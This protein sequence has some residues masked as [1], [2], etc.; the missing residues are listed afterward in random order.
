[1]I[2][3]FIRKIACYHLKEA[4]IISGTIK[5]MHRKK[6][7]LKS[8]NISSERGES[9][10]SRAMTQAN[11]SLEN[12]ATLLEQLV[13][14]AE[15][16]ERALPA[17]NAAARL[18]VRV[19]AELAQQALNESRDL[20][21]VSQLS[22]LADQPFSPREHQVLELAA[23]GLTNKEIAYRL[24]I[25]ERTVQFHINSIFNKTG[26]QSRTEAV[27]QAI[28]QGWITRKE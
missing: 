15:V 18:A 7:A 26:T 19:L 6:P 3:V 11:A 27:V 14:Q 17:E 20:V 8:G 16:Y 23:L 1:L 28:H 24:G 13:A 22:A 4:S 12:L 21:E 25:S 9:D 2:P 10:D 5:K